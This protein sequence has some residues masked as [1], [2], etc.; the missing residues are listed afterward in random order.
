MVYPL[1][2]GPTPDSALH[3]THHPD[4]P[5]AADDRTRLSPLG[6]RSTLDDEGHH[7]TSALTGSTT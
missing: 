2:G 6:D 5:S 1:T 4:Q 3:V 7:V